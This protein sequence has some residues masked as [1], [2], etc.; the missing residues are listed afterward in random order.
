MPSIS[1][2]GEMKLGIEFQSICKEVTIPQAEAKMCK[3]RSHYYK[4][5]CLHDTT[6]AIVCR[7][8]GFSGGNCK[9]R[10]KRC[11]CTWLC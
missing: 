5:P 8:S 6:C 9:G 1:H 10:R 11:F 7:D 2:D 4:G 3:S